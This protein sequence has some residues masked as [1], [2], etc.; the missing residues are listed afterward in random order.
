MATV[1]IPDLIADRREQ[2][3]AFMDEHVYPNESALARE[4]D[5]ADALVVELRQEAKAPTCGRRICRPRR[6]ARAAASSS[7]R[8]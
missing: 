7:T 2:V 6:A 8:T 4:D 5:A 3:R 1:V